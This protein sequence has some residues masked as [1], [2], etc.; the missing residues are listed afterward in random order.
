M[1]TDIKGGLAPKSG[2]KMEKWIQENKV[3]AI[4]VLWNADWCIQGI[5]V[6]ISESLDFVRNVI[7]ENN[8]IWKEEDR[9]ENE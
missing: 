5:S 3:E 1:K 7:E 6:A 9:E 2:E 4:R 8:T